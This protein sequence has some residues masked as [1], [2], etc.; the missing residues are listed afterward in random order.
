MARFRRAELTRYGAP[1]AFLVAAT[2]AVLAVRAGLH[3]DSTV[4]TTPTTSLVRTA[5]IPATSAPGRRK[6]RVYYE[7]R[8]GDTLETVAA[9]FDTTVHQLLLFNPG[10]KPTSLRVGQKLRVH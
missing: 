4:P 3:E 9:R 10:V 2:I 5:P 1:A 7:L 8:A 6:K